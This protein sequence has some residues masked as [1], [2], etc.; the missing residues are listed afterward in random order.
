MF[1]TIADTT[2]LLGECPVWC[3]GTERLFW[4]D[5]PACELLALDP[6]SGECIA[7]Q[8]RSHWSHMPSQQIKTYC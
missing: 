5:I 4:N 3:E 7:G 8:C 6:I 2:S 1:K